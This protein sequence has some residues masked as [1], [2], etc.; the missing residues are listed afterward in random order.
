MR[1]LLFA[2]CGGC[3]KAVH[4]RHL[5][6]HQHDIERPT[7]RRFGPGSQCFGSVVRHRDVVAPLRQQSDRQLLIG[8][9]VLGQQD[10]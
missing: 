10:S 7:V 5:H 8:Q 6:V 1:S 2:D 9:V 4:L 3:F